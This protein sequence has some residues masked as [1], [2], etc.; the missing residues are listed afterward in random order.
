MNS[1]KRIIGKN[2]L[3]AV[4]VILV[5]IAISAAIRGGDW[6][7]VWDKMWLWANFLLLVTAIYW[8]GWPFFIKMLD[9]RISGIAKD[10]SDFEKENAEI[11]AEIKN[12]E[13]QLANSENR[14]AQIKNTLEQEMALKREQ[15]IANAK[16]EAAAIFEQAELQHQIIIN[17]TKKNLKAELVDI[18]INNALAKL[19]KTITDKDQKHLF[20]VF[21]R[22]AF[23]TP[24]EA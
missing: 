18:A 24:Q 20:E 17:E 4:I 23:K 1:K 14:F 6:R 15:I 2:I 13:D 7:P 8:W 22:H 21:Y 9:K 16:K 3:L 5:V 19:P 12:L 11:I 10:L